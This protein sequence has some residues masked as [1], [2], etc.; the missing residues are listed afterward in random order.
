MADPTYIPDHYARALANLT[1][2]LADKPNLEALLEVLMGEVQQLEDTA[3]ALV[4]QR[5]VELAAGAALDR[6]GAIVG[7]RRDG[8]AD[9]DYRRFI[10][11]R[12]ETNIGEGE[13]PRLLSVVA[14]I[15]GSEDVL[16]VPR[17]PAAYTLY[18]V[19]EDL[20]PIG[21][22]ARIAAQIG[23]LTPAGVG[24]RVVEAADGYFGFADDPS[25]DGFGEGVWAELTFDS[26]TS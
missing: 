6:L 17:H 3:Y 21:V 11:A 15:T 25:A 20:Y 12:I 9:A 4:L 24:Y 13:I 16:Y 14:T 26:S 22:Q 7:E 18:Y 23:E 10:Q 19:V 5:R 8:L 1:S 2:E